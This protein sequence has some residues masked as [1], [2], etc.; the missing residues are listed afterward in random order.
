MSIGAS[1]FG[2][3]TSFTNADSTALPFKH[4]GSHPAVPPSGPL[5]SQIIPN[6][7]QPGT[8]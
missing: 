3:D 6:A 1:V 7:L 8:L 2:V 5:S 4:E